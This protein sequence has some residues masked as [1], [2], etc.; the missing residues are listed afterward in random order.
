MREQR[1]TS[2]AG[3]GLILASILRLWIRAREGRVAKFRIATP[4]GASFTVAGGGYGYEMEALTPIEAEIF[5]VAAGSEEEF[6]A[7]AKDADALYAK[8]RPITKRMID[9]LT[10]CKI[11]ALGSVGVDSV[12]VAAA[13]AKGIP[14]TNCPDTFIEEVADHAMR[15]IL[16]THGRL[17]MQD[18]LVA[19]GRGAE[20]RP[21]LLQIP[22]LRGLT[23]GLFPVG[24]PPR[25]AAD[26]AIP[27]G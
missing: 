17:V 13:T 18:R 11:I 7:A 25:A 10:R 22:R 14:V 15:L 8:G 21:M 20:G 19:Q 6:A 2:P 3:D 27:V 9:G 24:P 12:D 1:L 26:G 4:A 5:E 16:A 23:L